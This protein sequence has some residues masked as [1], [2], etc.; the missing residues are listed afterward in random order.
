V[1]AGT[2]AAADAVGFVSR[3]WAADDLIAAIRIAAMGIHIDARPDVGP[4]TLTS[5]EQDVLAHIARGKT[6]NEIAGAL[7]LSLHTIKQHASATYRKLDAHNR[8]QAVE[9]A[10]QLGILA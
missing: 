10:R 8:T 2:V 7:N 5:R 6:N 3:S 4:V 1:A 9:H